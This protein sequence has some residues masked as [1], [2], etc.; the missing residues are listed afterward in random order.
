MSTG[1]TI[2][3]ALTDAAIRRHSSNLAIREIKDPA[4]PLRFRYH[5]G[6]KTG[7][8]HAVVYSGGAEIWRK[9][10]PWPAV[11]ASETISS[12]PRLL[13]SIITNPAEHAAISGMATFADLL[14]WYAD[15]S[16]TNR[17]ISPSR[18]AA[19]ASQIKCQLLPLFG[20]MPLTPP[21]HE[22][23]RA[24][25]HYQ[26]GYHAETARG[27]WG[28]LK[29]AVTQARKLR[30]ITHDPLDGIAFSDLIKVKASVKP[31][32]L[33]PSHVAEVLAQLSTSPAPDRLLCLLMLANATRIGET[34]QARWRD[35]DLVGDG[36]WHIPAAHTKPRRSHRIPLTSFTVR[37]LQSYRHWQQSNGY[38]GAYLFPGAKGE[39]L[40]AR[41]ASRLVASVSDR[42]WSAHDLR[43]LARTRWADQGVDYLVSELMLNHALSKLDKTYIN[44][45]VEGQIMSAFVHYHQWL[46]AQMLLK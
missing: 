22:L 36:A 41:E 20:S 4:H 42:E 28:I 32:R 17:Q 10:A 29:Q 15:R 8:M 7:S 44:T 19:I 9:V 45:L 26:Q 6:R 33:R 39:P 13:A 25:Q 34:R 2:H 37:E 12:L 16:S 43:K 31:G 30:L 38:S 21:R 5:K 3:C 24:M 46:E 18:R 14:T 11:T 40:S 1:P 35:I 23:D 27:G